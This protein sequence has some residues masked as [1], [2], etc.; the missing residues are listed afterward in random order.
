M[1]AKFSRLELLIGNDKMETLKNKKVII[2]GVGGVGGYVAEALIRSGINNI[3][4]VDNDVVDITNLNRQII[5][6][7]DAVNKDKVE[8]M[9]KRMLSINDEANI[10]ALKKYYSPDNSDEFKL[11]GYDYIVDCIDTITSKIDLICKADK[12]NIKIISAMGAGNKIN[13]AMLEVSDIY[14]TEMDPL[15]K[16]I[17]KELKARGIKRLKVVYS[18]EKPLETIIKM[19][20]EDSRKDIPGSTAFVPATMGLI[21]ASEV[22]KDLIG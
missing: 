5:A 1:D 17:R 9:K 4:I 21:M 20:R 15:A 10:T 22:V 6:T 16:V 14:K 2:F 8:V 11:D 7:L 18:K 3:T 19:S 13:P 12:L